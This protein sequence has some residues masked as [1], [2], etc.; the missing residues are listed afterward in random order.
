MRGSAVL[1]Q[2]GAANEN[3]FQSRCGAW[4]ISGMTVCKGKENSMQDTLYAE[5]Q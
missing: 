3:S 2:F 1:E 5:A 4:P